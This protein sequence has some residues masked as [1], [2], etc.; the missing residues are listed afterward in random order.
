MASAELSRLR[1]ST[2][3]RSLALES[4]QVIDTVC[5]VKRD[6]GGRLCVVTSV[7]RYQLSLFCYSC[8]GGPDER[9]GGAP[10][11]PLQRGRTRSWSNV[12]GGG[13]ASQLDINVRVGE[14]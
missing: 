3:M 6:C 14:W 9:S 8:R 12:F 1:A 13:A 7:H 2:L 4:I 11:G 5:N 10:S